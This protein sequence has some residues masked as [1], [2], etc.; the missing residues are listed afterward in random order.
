MRQALEEARLCGAA[1]GRGIGA[2][3]VHDGTIIARSGPRKESFKNPTGH[4]EVLCIQEAAR[5][6]GRADMSDCSLYTTLEPCPMCAGTIAVNS[7]ATVVVG[8]RQAGHERHW[9]EYTIESLIA[10]TGKQQQVQ[11]ITGVLYEECM[12]MLREWDERNGVTGR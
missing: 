8:A 10:L 1:G 5:V 9:G 2:V 12:S 6:L 4:A 3:L 7:V 11:V